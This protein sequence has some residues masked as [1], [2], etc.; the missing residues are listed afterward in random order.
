MTKI[1]GASYLIDSHAHLNSY[2]TE[3]IQMIINECNEKNIKI[4]HTIST[5]LKE[6]KEIQLIAEKYNNVIY[7]IGVHPLYIEENS[8]KS[9]DVFSTLIK[10]STNKKVVSIGETG[11]DLFKNE[12]SLSTQIKYFEKHIEACQETNLPIVIHSRDA[13]SFLLDIISSKIKEK[14]FNGVMHCFTSSKETAFKM[15]DLGFLISASGIITFP[16]SSELRDT[17]ENIPLDKLLIETDAPYLAPN[18]YRGKKNYPYYIVETAKTLAS[19]KD[20]SFD[21]ISYI[22]TENF[23]KIFKK[24]NIVI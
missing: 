22:T 19:I 17:F 7:S 18:K 2:D 1:K 21:E 13:D 10:L 23:L 12:I 24:S 11:L 4:I 9:E 20:I 3:E 14:T 5:N 6:I 16:K 15:I 8:F